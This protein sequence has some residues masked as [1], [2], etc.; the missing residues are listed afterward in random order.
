LPRAD[1]VEEDTIHYTG[2]HM[3]TREIVEE[4]DL[5]IPFP[6]Q[7]EGVIAYFSQMILKG[8]RMP[9]HFAELVPLV[10]EYIR[11]ILFG[12]EIDLNSSAVLSRLSEP[13]AQQIIIT[14]FAQAINNLTIESHPVRIQ[15][16]PIRL[17]ATNAFPWTKG[18]YPAHKTI[19]NLVACDSHYEAEF[20]AFLDG[21]PGAAA[22]AK[23]TEA[24]HFA[25]EYLSSQGGVRYYYP[26]FIVRLVSSEMFVVETKGL[27]DIEVARKDARATKW[28]QDATALSG[29]SWHYIKVPENVFR[30]TTA[31]TFEQLYHHTLAAT[32]P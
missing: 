22:F 25:I 17:S 31:T 28:C 23:N 2:R 7:P 8:A 9:G 26:D 10:K 1:L 32:Q 19:F 14:A 11:T 6:D 4:K 5:L 27:E 18:T 15:G 3:L 29:V 24:T 21:V 12:H 30:S 13:D 16:N 20:A